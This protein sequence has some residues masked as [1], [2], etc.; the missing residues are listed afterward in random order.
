MFNTVFVEKDQY[1]NAQE[2]LSKIKYRDLKVIDKIEDIWGRVKK[3]YLQKRTTLNLFIGRKKG[4]LLKEA[5]SAYGVGS[6]K[7]FYYIHAY[8]CIYECEYCYLQGYFNSPD[9]VLFINHQEILNE[10]ERTIEQYPDAWFHSGEF[11][12]SLALSH[13][14]C[15]LPGYHKLFE[16]YPNAK[17]EIRT[18]SV[19]LK[20]IL[21]LS[22]LPNI[23]CSFSIAPEQAIKKF[24]Y[25][26][27][28]LKHRLNA[29]KTLVHAGHPIGIHLDP[30]VYHPEFENEYRA[31][32]LDLMGVLPDSSLTYISLGVVRFT[33]D[34]YQQVKNNYPDSPL[35]IERYHKSFDGKIRYPAPMRAWILNTVKEMLLPFYQSEKIYLCMED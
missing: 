31:L 26:C 2:L 5:P 15:E 23:I 12:D 35:T 18:K 25:K 19:N 11:S 6:E 20:E 9:I 21:N 28:S 14:T 7:H 10:I 1:Q 30:I 4:Q 34:V 24:D 29:I 8:N 33:G 27:P 22:P 32:I 16:R 13:I 17:L 3:P